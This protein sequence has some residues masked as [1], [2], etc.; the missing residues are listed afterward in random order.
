MLLDASRSCHTAKYSSAIIR[1][2]LVVLAFFFAAFG[3]GLPADTAAQIEVN[4]PFEGTVG[5]GKK[6]SVSVELAAD[7]YA[8]FRVES[9]TTKVG[10]TQI[11]PNGERLGLIGF[12]NLTQNSK[13]AIVAT[14]AGKYQVEIFASSRAA[15]GTFRITLL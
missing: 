1:L 10:V 13:F 3:Q 12:S 15:E 8:Q 9:E 7:Q 4:K 14:A 5:A 11:K 6:Q 2:S